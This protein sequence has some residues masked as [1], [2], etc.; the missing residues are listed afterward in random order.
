[1]RSLLDLIHSLSSGAGSAPP[2]GTAPQRDPEALQP[3]G[4]DSPAAPG[5]WYRAGLFDP[6]AQP[7]ESHGT[8]ASEPSPYSA[9]FHPFEKLKAFG[10]PESVYNSGAVP[11][12]GPLAAP[13]SDHSVFSLSEGAGSASTQ[14]TFGSPRSNARIPQAL[15]GS[16]QSVQARWGIPASVTI[17][18]WI[19]ESGWG[20][21]T[22]PGS[23]N[24]FGVKAGKDEPYVLASTPEVV[25]GK[26][27]RVIARFK[28]Y[29]T[30]EDG[31]QDHARLLFSNPAYA[32]A[33]A[34]TDDPEGFVDYI[35][36]YATNPDYHDNLVR[37]IRQHNLPQYDLPP[38]SR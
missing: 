12:Q 19:E 33:L 4:F 24:Y 1:M 18:Q 5:A 32:G 8:P 29:P 20:E 36:R 17:A 25:N 21:H 30:Q 6:A 26:K 37:H 2:P 10:F 35:T 22:P 15:I 28:K 38:H 13:P 11:A 34:H 14:A 16:A 31:M 9:P 7:Q 3:G 27:E 23:N